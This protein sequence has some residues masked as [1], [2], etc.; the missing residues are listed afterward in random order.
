MKAR[1]IKTWTGQKNNT[2]E[3]ESQSMKRQFIVIATL[4]AVSLFLF[5]CAKPVERAQ[6]LFDQGKYEEVITKYTADQ[7]CADVVKNSKDKL[8]EGLMASKNYQEVV[9]KYPDSKYAPEA[10]K[11]LDEQAAAALLGQQ[12]FQEVVDKYPTTAA[13]NQAR[14]QLATALYGDG[15]DAKKVEECFQKFP[16]TNFVKTTKNKMATE[17]LEKIMKAK[18]KAKVKKLE[19][20]VKNPKYAGTEAVMKAQQEIANAAKPAE[21]GAKGAKPAPKKK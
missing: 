20:F 9:T 10:K 17:E 19:E 15:K 4:I 1:E 6:K 11:Q 3:E 18:G 14:E 2:L 5:G 8:A 7:T 12:K 13:A 16:M 21:K